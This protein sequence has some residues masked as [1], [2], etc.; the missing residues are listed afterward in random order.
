MIH[1]MKAA[2]LLKERLLFG[3]ESFAE[4]IIWRLPRP[5]PGSVHTYKYRLA[6]IV[7]GEC[8]LRY[9]NEAS[10][11]DH[12]HTPT[13]ELPYAFESPE[14]L[15]EDFLREARRIDRENRDS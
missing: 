8:L 4:L 12:R 10:K 13:R 11:G 2:L 6:F 1:N 5:A 15:V 14:K 7:A 3:D 9:D